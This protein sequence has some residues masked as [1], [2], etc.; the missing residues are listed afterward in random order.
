MHPALHPDRNQ[1][2]CGLKP[3]TTFRRSATFIFV[4]AALL[5]ANSG[6]SQAKESIPN[7][8]FEGPQVPN[9]VPRKVAQ[10]LNY[11]PAPAP[12]KDNIVPP[13]GEN[14]YYP[15][16]SDGQPYMLILDKTI[17]MTESINR[18]YYDPKWRGELWVP[19]DPLTYP[20][21]ATRLMAT[22]QEY[23]QQNIYRVGNGIARWIEKVSGFGP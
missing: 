2:Q 6:P 16:R 5:L 11:P 1:S 15:I 7:R 19:A 17:N 22:W 21:K 20:E 10:Q 4:V 13:G 18:F 12:S 23:D 9:E 3:L 8:L 14:Q